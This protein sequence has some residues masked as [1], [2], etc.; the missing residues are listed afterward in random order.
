[1][2]IGEPRLFEWVFATSEN[3]L[4]SC[5]C[6]LPAGVSEIAWIAQDLL[7]RNSKEWGGS[8]P[9]RPVAGHSR[10]GVKQ[11]QSITSHS[12]PG[13]PNHQ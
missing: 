6:P 1:M 7:H 2:P 12:S 4:I 11:R 9:S 8:H 10:R 5:D 13:Q 3:P